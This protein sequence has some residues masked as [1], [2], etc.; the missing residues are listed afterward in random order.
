M[1]WM[2]RLMRW[3]MLKKRLNLAR[4]G[5]IVWFALDAVR[6]PA[7]GGGHIVPSIFA[8]DAFVIV[9]QPAIKNDIGGI[10]YVGLG[11]VTRPD[12]ALR[13]GL[14]IVQLKPTA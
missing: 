2:K 3:M 11:Y 14:R 10:G 4:L 13:A 5:I 6:P 9:T 8:A 7:W 1:K 12:G